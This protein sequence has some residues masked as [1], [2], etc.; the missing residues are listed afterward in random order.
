[1][2]VYSTA[3]HDGTASTLHAQTTMVCERDCGC[4]VVLAAADNSMPLPQCQEILAFLKG[5][6]MHDIIGPELSVS[7]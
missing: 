2:L 5:Q 7:D 6:L 1:M 3:Q 4:L